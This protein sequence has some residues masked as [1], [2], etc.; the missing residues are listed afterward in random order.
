MDKNKQ[1]IPNAENP[2]E[3]LDM[4]LSKP[5]VVAAGMTAVLSSA[6]HVFSEM[7]VA[8]GLKVL[9]ALNQKD[10]F[11]CPGCAWPDPDGHSITHV[12]NSCENGAKAVA[13]RSHY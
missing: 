7:N 5:K 9:A 10:G 12:P 3:F 11:D 8:R 13:G 1:A 6:K 2:E 4:K